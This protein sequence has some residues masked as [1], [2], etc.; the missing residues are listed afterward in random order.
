MS[1]SCCGYGRRTGFLRAAG[2]VPCQPSAPRSACCG[3]RAWSA[4]FA[5]PLLTASAAGIEAYWDATVQ[6]TSDDNEERTE[7]IL[8][9]AGEFDIV[10][11][12]EAFSQQADQL[13]DGAL[14]GGFFALPGSGPREWRLPIEVSIGAQLASIPL[15][16]SGLFLLVRRDLYTPPIAISGPAG[17]LAQEVMRLAA[18]NHR[19]QLFAADCNGFTSDGSELYGA[20]GLHPEHRAFPN[21]LR[22]RGGPPSR[23]DTASTLIAS[24][25]RPRRDARDSR[26][27]SI[28]TLLPAHPAARSAHLR[29]RSSVP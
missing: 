3:S 1:A 10:A 25:S 23:S 15:Q 17:Q 28:H 29:S 6:N 8:E 19:S 9:R 24:S 13:I 20:K 5:E 27:G 16:S 4:P 21:T 12:Q 7:L 18:R 11:L 2:R 26:R 14:A 22:G